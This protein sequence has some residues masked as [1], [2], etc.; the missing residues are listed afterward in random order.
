MPIELRQMQTEPPVEKL[1]LALVGREKH[2]KSLLAATGRKN[3]LFHDFDNRAEALQGK[4]GVYV[5]S[6]I[7]PQWPKQPDAAQLFLDVLGKLEESLDIYDL[8]NGLPQLK[9]FYAKTGRQ[10]PPKGTLIR[11]NVIDSV[12]T[13]GKAFRYYGMFTQKDIRRTINIGKMQVFL[14]GGWDAWNAEMV[15]VEN[16][17][18]RLLGL[19]TDTILIFH[20]KLEEAED[21]TDDRP[22]YTGKVGVYP[23]RYQSLIKYVNELW[24]VKLTQSVANGKSAFLP[25][26][27]P[28]PT[29]EFDAATTMLLDPVEEPN[30]E[31][32]IA[33]HAAKLKGLLGSTPGQK[34][35]EVQASPAQPQ[36]K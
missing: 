11:T 19:P 6:Y 30:I 31:A 33:K 29:Y 14:P 27:Y 8:I 25:K 32:M 28:F 9:E 10:I 20:Q 1:K 22:K 18:L 36:L 7:D 26:V 4:P 34:V 35:V 21:S 17:I 23:A 3:V 5:L 13:F 2:G 15:P 16:N 24:Q 12:Q